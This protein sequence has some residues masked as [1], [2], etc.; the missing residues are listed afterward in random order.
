MMLYYKALLIR[1]AL[2]A[3]G[4]II[5]SLVFCF[6]AD[7]NLVY[8][9][10]MGLVFFLIGKPNPFKISSDMELPDEE[11]KQLFENTTSSKDDEN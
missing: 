4:I 2:L 8:I 7:T 11:K 1:F 10:A 9:A 3:S 5:I 6:T